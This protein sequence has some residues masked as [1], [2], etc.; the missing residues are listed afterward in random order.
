V[1]TTTKEK[2]TLTTTAPKPSNLDSYPVLVLNADYTP[3]SYHPLST[4]PWW[5][6][7]KLVYEGVMI[8]LHYYDD[9]F[10]TS[11]HEKHPLPSVV[12]HREMV[13]TRGDRVPFTKFNVFLRDDFRCQYCAKKF[14][15][16]D[17]TYE[18]VFPKSRGGKAV[19]DNIAAAC[20][21]CNEKKDNRTPE[22]A[23]MRLLRTP[24]E[25]TVWEIQKKGRKYPPRYLHATWADYLYWDTEL[26]A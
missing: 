3:E 12:I 26:E 23:K 14:P 19:W 25:P 4:R 8:P 5:E 11:A 18:H 6:I 24:Y 10:V 2:E 7:M 9:V 17:L 22:E 16:S 21:P 15:A 20:Q 13:S 1:K